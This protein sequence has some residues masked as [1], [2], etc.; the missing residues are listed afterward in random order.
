[1]SSLPRRPLTAFRFATAIALA[2]GPIAAR[3]DVGVRVPVEAT[4]D[5]VAAITVAVQR[6]AHRVT[7]LMRFQLTQTEDNHEY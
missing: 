4:P 2:V 5:E 3:A 7:L 6:T 1:M